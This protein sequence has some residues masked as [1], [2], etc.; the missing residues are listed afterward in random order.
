MPTEAD[1][2][3]ER[4]FRSITD[5]AKFRDWSESNLSYQAAKDQLRKELRKWLIEELASLN[6]IESTDAWD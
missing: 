4:V 3:W 6:L 1:E 2:A 5:S